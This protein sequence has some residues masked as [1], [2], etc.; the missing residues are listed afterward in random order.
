MKH[1]AVFTDG[2]LL[3][4]PWFPRYLFFVAVGQEFIIKVKGTSVWVVGYPFCF[5]IDSWR[6]LK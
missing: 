6:I 2:E 1:I 3:K 4:Q 5:H